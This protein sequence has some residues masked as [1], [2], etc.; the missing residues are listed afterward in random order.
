MEAFI[1]LTNAA[2][3]FITERLD[4]IERNEFNDYTP[5]DMESAQRE[6]GLIESEIDAL[7]TLLN[8]ARAIAAMKHP[9]VESLLRRCGYGYEADRVANIVLAVSALNADHPLKKD[10]E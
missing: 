9:S 2:R 1:N 7:T 6:H 8:A 4:T 5:E 10:A 3:E